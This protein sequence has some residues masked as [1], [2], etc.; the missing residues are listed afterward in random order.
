M[1]TYLIT[2]AAQGLGKA[3]SRQLVEKG[4]QVIL[5]DKELKALNALYDEL[6]SDLI[7]LYPMDLL[8]ANIDHYQALQET[9]T[10]EYGQLNGVILNAAILP[11]FTPIENFDYMQWY[12]VLHTNLNANLHLIQNT[13][14]LLK[15]SENG[16]LLAVLDQSI[17][18]HPAYYGAY[19]VAKA[20]LEQLITTLAAEHKNT[21]LDIY[22]AKLEAFATEARGRLFPGENPLDLISAENMAERILESILNAKEHPSIR[23]L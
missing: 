8:G 9:I 18:L 5:L 17:D 4:H 1:Q 7:A 13:L 10:E 3:L 2:G 16:K 6:D 15:K 21:D 20:G 12:E 22:T 14:G 19:G 23:C 11:A